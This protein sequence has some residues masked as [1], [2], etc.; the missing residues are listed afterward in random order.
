MAGKMTSPNVE[1]VKICSKEELDQAHKIRHDVFVVGQNVPADEE[2]DRYEDQCTHFLAKINDIPCGAARWRKTDH[3]MKLERF[4]VLEAYRNRGVGSA[5]V[6]A[7]ISDIQSNS[8][9]E[10]QSL[11]LHAQLSAIPLYQKFGF[12]KEGEVFQECDIDH[13]AMIRK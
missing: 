12:V 10:H 4:A 9:T 8:A 7:V 5:L 1:V 13:Y 3:G 6:E 11:Y 2:I